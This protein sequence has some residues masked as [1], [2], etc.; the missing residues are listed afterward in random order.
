M[1][2]ISMFYG[3]IIRMFFDEHCPPR[4]H[5][6]YQGIES[7]FTLDGECTDDKLPKRQRR[8]VE[9]WAE[10]HHDELVANWELARNQESLFVIEPLR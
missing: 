7:L 10:L 2:T 8:F 9:A 6:I 3:I 4:F 5:A 1:P